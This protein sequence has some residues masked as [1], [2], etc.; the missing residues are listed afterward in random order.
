MAYCPK[1]GVEVENDIKTCPLCKFPIPDISDPELSELKKLAR[2]PE[3]KNI[4]S[5]YLEGIKNQVYFVVIVLLISVLL[6][7]TVIEGVFKVDS[8]LVKYFYVV[9]IGMAAY[10][11]FGLGF[12]RWSINIT[13]IGLTTLF[14]LYSIGVIEGGQWFMTYGLPICFLTYLNSIG[15]HMMYKH[16]KRKNRLG[17]VPSFILLIVTSLAI[18]IDGVVSWNMRGAVHLTWSLVA[19]MICLCVAYLLHFII[20]H[21]PESTKETIR[22]RLHL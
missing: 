12:H 5:D 21:M 16:S 6:V 18:G 2:Y 3:V 15:F 4:Y 13:G 20:N 17:Y 8:I 22:R 10:V 7:L 9:T 1:C 19:A 14:L 11:Y